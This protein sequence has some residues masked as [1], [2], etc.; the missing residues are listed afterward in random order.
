MAAWS[1]AGLF[2][3]LDTLDL[4]ARRAALMDASSHPG[5]G[6]LFVRGLPR[7]VIDRLCADHD[8]A[9]AIVN[10]DLAFV[11]GGDGT[12]LDALARD[13]GRHGATRVQRLAVQVASHTPRLAEA[14]T[15]FQADLDLR[16]PMRRSPG[17][18]LLSGIDGAMVSDPAAGRRNLAAQ[19]ASPVRWATCLEACIEA[20]ATAFLELGPGHAL[21]DMAASAYP[22]VPARSLDQFR[23]SRGI[24]AWIEAAG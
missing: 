12:H 19:I 23:S 17:V 11:L 14:A 10:P 4:A 8:A 5:D 7:D 3:P 13:A 16:G 22:R 6:L 21:S 2:D 24:R 15:R 18:R 1:L 9:V 20:G